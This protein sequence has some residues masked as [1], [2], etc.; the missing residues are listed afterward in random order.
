M[1]SSTAIGGPQGALDRAL[2]ADAMF[3][4]TT[5][6]VTPSLVTVDAGIATR[7]ARRYVVRPRTPFTLS[8]P[9]D[10]WTQLVGRFPEGRFTIEILGHPLD[11]VFHAPTGLPPTR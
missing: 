2:I 5:G 1:A 8:G 3:A 10:A 11:I 9:D 7:L 4:Q 6:G